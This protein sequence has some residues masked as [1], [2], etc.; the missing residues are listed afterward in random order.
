MEKSA[1]DVKAVLGSRLL[2][3]LYLVTIAKST[4]VNT[5]AKVPRAF[6]VEVSNLSS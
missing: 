6:A 2:P 4:S 1:T 3:S 5:G